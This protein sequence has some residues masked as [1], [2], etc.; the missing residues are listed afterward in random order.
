MKGSVF[1]IGYF[2]LLITALITSYTKGDYSTAI[3]IFLA[4]IVIS[5]FLKEATK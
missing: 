3:A 4:M 2:I 5:L 1:V